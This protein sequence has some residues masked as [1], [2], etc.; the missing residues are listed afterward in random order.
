MAGDAPF[1]SRSFLLYWCA[2]AVLTLNG[3]TLQVGW[4]NS[5]RWLPYLMVGIVVGALVDRCR[6][7]PIMMATDW[8]QAVLLGLIPLLW[9]LHLLSFPALL[10]S[11]LVHGIASVINGGDVLDALPGQCLVVPGDHILRVPG[12]VAAMVASHDRFVRSFDEWLGRY[13]HTS[14]S[15]R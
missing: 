7:L 12:D 13:G 14:C 10:A 15:H 2:N 6:R 11:T 1:P 9:W 5:V 3:S 4:L 8:A